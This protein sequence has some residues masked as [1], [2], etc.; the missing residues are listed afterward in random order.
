MDLLFS[1]EVRGFCY[2][3]ISQKQAVKW[4]RKQKL[5]F[6][7]RFPDLST[8]KHAYLHFFFLPH[9]TSCTTS[10][11]LKSYEVNT[12]EIIYVGFKPSVKTSYAGIHDYVAVSDILKLF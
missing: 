1:L 11:L 10:I 9:T 5:F 3:G 4:G 12:K 8:F 2:T 6:E 7:K